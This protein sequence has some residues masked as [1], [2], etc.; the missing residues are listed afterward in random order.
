MRVLSFVSQKGGVGKSTLTLSCAVAAEQNGYRVLI[1]DMDP[2]GTAEAWYQ[3]RDADTPQL[4]TAAGTELGEALARARAV[5]FDFVLI[6]TP[7]RDEPAVAA[8]IRLS[9]FCIVPC[10]PS[11]ADMKATP[12]TFATIQRVGKPAA[13][14]LTQTPARGARI[15]EAQVGLGMLGPVAPV[16]LVSRHSYQDAQGS[17]LAVTEFEPEGK[18]ADEVRRLWGWLA[19]KVKKLSDGQETH[20]A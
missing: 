19:R 17:G 16:H 20:V 7:G 15:R 18:A 14:V 8:A 6:D 2:Q 11:P 9:D 10:R 5:G 4:V 13:F 1:V 12:P 3:D